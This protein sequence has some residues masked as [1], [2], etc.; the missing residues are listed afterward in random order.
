[1]LTTAPSTTEPNT[2][3]QEASLHLKTHLQLAPFLDSRYSQR[4]PIIT[5]M[6]DGLACLPMQQPFIGRSETDTGKEVH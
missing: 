1:M 5:R 4:S 6:I 3:Q 2:D